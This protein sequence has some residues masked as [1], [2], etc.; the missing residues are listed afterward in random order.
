MYIG[1]VYPPIR[2]CLEVALVQPDGADGM[3]TRTVGTWDMGADSFEVLAAKE[4]REAFA[5]WA[6]LTVVELDA[7]LV[8]REGI[9][10]EWMSSGAT[11]IPEVNN[12]IEAF[13][14][15]GMAEPA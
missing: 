9:I 8:R 6:G 4:E 7:E 13:H 12:A 3:K 2:R 14:A 10:H 15:E 1:Q 5:G 11:S